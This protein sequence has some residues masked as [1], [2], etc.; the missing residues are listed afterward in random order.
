MEL[1]L[2]KLKSLRL[3]Y[4]EDEEGIRKPMANTLS[5]YLKEVLEAR[6]GEEALDIYYE[7]RPDIIL[8]D[9]RMPRKDGLYMVKEIRKIDKKTPILMITA[10]TDKEYLLSAIEL[11]IEKYLIKPVALDE[12]LGAL[13]LCVTEIES[14]RSLFLECKN[15]KFDFN[16]KRIIHSDGSEVE[17]THKES[18]F[19]ELLL[20]KK[21]M[22]VSYEEIEMNVWKEEYMSIAA[23]RTLVKSLR[24]KLPN[25]S[26]KN[27]SQTGYSF[28]I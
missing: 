9:L 19:L 14:G 22:I 6:D 17:L 5:Y 18:D 26:I 3:L 23:L 12:L 13:K 24:K 2:E 27:H 21:G 16:A 4:A 15:C 20:R 8:T 28:E 25:S 11:K 1:W 7:Q 10:H